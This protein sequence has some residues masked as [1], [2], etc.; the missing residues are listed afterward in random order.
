MSRHEALGNAIESAVRK[1]C[2]GKEVGIAF[3]GGMDSGLVAAL[4]KK[5][6]RSV[7]CYT[8]GTDWTNVK[9]VGFNVIDEDLF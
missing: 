3:S 2:E 5:Y 6:A 9:I 1:A 7:T 8:C 4:A